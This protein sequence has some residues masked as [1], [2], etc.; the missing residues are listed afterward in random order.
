MYVGTPQDG[1]AGAS[2]AFVHERC[3]RMLELQ[4]LLGFLPFPGTLNL[5]L[6]RDF[7]FAAPH[8]QADILDRTRKGR[9]FD[10]PWAPRPCKLWPMKIDGRPCWAIRFD[11]KKYK[12]NFAEII[13]DVRLR[14]FIGETVR[15]EHDA[16][17]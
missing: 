16:L 13:S 9:N 1:G 2:K 14:E 8:I 5:K 12:F 10:H 4:S 7:D 3:R 17:P 15:L 6:D 11:D